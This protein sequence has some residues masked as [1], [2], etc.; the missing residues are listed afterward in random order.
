MPRGFL[1]DLLVATLQGAFALAEVDN[2]AVFVG[3]DLHLDVTTGVD[4]VLEEQRVVAERTGRLTA[5]G[6]KRIGQV[7][8]SPTRCMP[9]P[10]PPALGLISTGTRFRGSGDQLVVGKPGPRQPRHDGYSRCDTAA[11]AVILS[12]IVAIADAGGPMNTI[13]ASASAAAKSWFSERKPYPGCTASAPDATAAANHLVDVEVA[14]RR[15]CG[16]DTDG[17]V[18]RPTCGACSSAS[19]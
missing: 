17:D 3:K 18:G 12:P 19:E 6:D 13:P 11:R 15:R 16:P 8:G 2:R 5:R 7:G 4:E 10:P 14:L 9:F 1:D